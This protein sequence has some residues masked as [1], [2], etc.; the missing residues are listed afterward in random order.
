MKFT[1]D[2]YEIRKQNLKDLYCETNV[3]Y[4]TLM[5]EQET[6]DRYLYGKLRIDDWAARQFEGCLGLKE[7]AFDEPLNVWSP[8]TE[9]PEPISYQIGG[10]HY[11]DMDV[12]PWEVIASWPVEQRIGFFRGNALKY[13]MR[14]GMKGDTLEDYRKAKHYLEMLLE[15]AE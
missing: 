15:T 8:L 1:R 14:A 13:L 10:S 9:N 6:F 2:I 7:F 11:K 12:E 5:I 4:D 3:D